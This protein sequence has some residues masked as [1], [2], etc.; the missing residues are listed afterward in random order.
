M[1]YNITNKNQLAD[2]ALTNQRW[3]WHHGWECCRYNRNCIW[4]QQSVDG[5]CQQAAVEVMAATVTAK[6]IILKAAINIRQQN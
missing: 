1:K 5:K 4:S 3:R 2:M 6:S